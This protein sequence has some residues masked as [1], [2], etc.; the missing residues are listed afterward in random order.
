VSDSNYQNC[1]LGFSDGHSLINPIN[2]AASNQF[3][4]AISFVAIGSNIDR[5]RL[6]MTAGYNYGFVTYVNADDNI[7]E[8]VLEVFGKINA[9]II[10]SVAIDYNKPDV[11]LLVPTPYPTIN[12]GSSFY[13]AGRYTT[14]SQTPL[15]LYGKGILGAL[16][17]SFPAIYSADTS[18][19]YYIRYLW[20]KAM[21]DNLERKIL[22]YGEDPVLKDS[23]I[24]ISLQYKMKCRYTAYITV[25]E[26]GGSTT[27]IETT[28]AADAKN[29]D[30]VV[31]PNPFGDK[32]IV[33]LTVPTQD[34]CGTRLLKIYSSTGILLK[35]IDI[36]GISEGKNL[37]EVEFSGLPVGIY[38]LIYQKD[39]VRIKT[40]KVVHI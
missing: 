34:K 13:V 39:N 29:D 38:F 10:K 14:S 40:L 22:I 6:E 35:V 17:H 18:N 7:R 5:E 4:T 24:H 19:E 26:A 25:E 33:S 2:L 37:V 27:G 36:S 32:M 9:P 31:M 1:I 8:K 23:L 3:K 12:A 16:S 30:M 15:T 28:A 11:D 21:M 20:A